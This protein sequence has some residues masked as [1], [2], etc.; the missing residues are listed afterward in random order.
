MTTYAQETEE[1]RIEREQA[2]QDFDNF[3]ALWERLKQSIRE[4]RE[5]SAIYTM[6]G[7][8]DRDHARV[9]TGN[10]DEDDDGTPFVSLHV[11]M[12]RASMMAY[13]R[14]EDLINIAEHCL[15]RAAQMTEK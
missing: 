13:A 7:H 2:R 14:R 10:P 4:R 1:D 15:L 11:S 3:D 9:D 5:P 8:L 12:S 6:N